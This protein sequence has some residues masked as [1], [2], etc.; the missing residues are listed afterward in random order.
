M[1][2]AELRKALEGL[3]DD[4]P[5][6]IRDDGPSSLLVEISVVRSIDWD[7]PQKHAKEELILRASSSISN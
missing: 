7:H 5:V 1:T 3:P 6:K 2:V 4:M